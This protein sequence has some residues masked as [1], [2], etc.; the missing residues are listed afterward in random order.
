V[1][2]GG[3]PFKG[4]FE[5]NDLVAVLVSQA[6]EEVLESDFFEPL[7]ELVAENQ[8]E[9]ALRAQ[10]MAQDLAIQLIAGQLSQAGLQIVGRQQITILDTATLTRFHIKNALVPDPETP[11]RS[12]AVDFDYH[13]SSRKASGVYVGTLKKTLPG[14]IPLL[15]LPDIILGNVQGAEREADIIK[16][17]E[18]DFAKKQ[19][20]VSLS[21]IELEDSETVFLSALTL[22]TLPLRISANYDISSGRL[23]DVEHDQYEAADGTPEEVFTEMARPF[24]RDYLFEHG[25]SIET[26]QIV[27]EFPFGTVTV[28]DVGDERVQFDFDV[29]INGNRLENVVVKSTG[30]RVDSM[31]FEEFNNIFRSEIGQAE[32]KKAAE[33]NQVPEEN[34][35]EEE[36]EIPGEEAL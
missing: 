4:S 5:L 17:I 27:T 29:D 31:T 18:T 21:D 9:E 22:T 14:E 6:G 2:V 13:S 3:E 26:K 19:I 8:D 34:S 20:Q 16:R 24:I 32:A 35:E 25:V 33:E 15:N 28:L 30:A 23:S 1:E 12:V 36:P 10:L 11:G 7:T